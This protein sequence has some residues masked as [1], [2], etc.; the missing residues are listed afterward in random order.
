MERKL[1]SVRQVAEVRPIEG[2]DAI[3]KVIIDGWQVVSQKG[4]HS[5]GDYV[6]YFEIDSFLPTDRS[7]FDFLKAKEG[8]KKTVFN[9]IE[10]HRLRTIRLRK[11]LSQGL[12]ISFK[13][14]ERMPFVTVDETVLSI[15]WSEVFGV[16]KYDKPL[17]TQLAGTVRSTFRTDLMPK[18]DQERVQNIINDLIRRKTDDPSETFEVTLK[19]DGSSMTVYKFGDDYGVSSRNMDLLEDDNNTFWQVA[20]EKRIHDW[21]NSI[22]RDLAVQGELVGEGIQNN[23]EGISGKNFF[24]FDIYDITSKRY[25]S[26]EERHMILPI[27]ILHVPII[28][29]YFSLPISGEWSTSNNRE[30]MLNVLLQKANVMNLSNKRAGEGIV[31]K[32]NKDPS[33]SFKIISNDYLLNE[34]D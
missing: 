30:Y 31:L 4:I 6:F 8:G 32:S 7:E 14:V 16:Q 24:V 19:L 25:L 26:P 10:G 27:H 1:V 2:A 28:H 15:D 11:T 5:V 21:L 29:N 33:F 18:T 9:G 3:E 13:H 23:A 34:K 20:K 12:I 22:G 17:P